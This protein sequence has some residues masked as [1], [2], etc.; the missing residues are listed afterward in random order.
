MSLVDLSREL[1]GLLAE[2]HQWREVG[3]ALL[4]LEHRFPGLAE[5]INA[6]RLLLQQA[7][8]IPRKRKKGRR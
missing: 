2:L 5:A 1:N 7:P 4:R 3:A 6:E 8:P